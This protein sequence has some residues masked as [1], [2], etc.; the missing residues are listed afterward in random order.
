MQTVNIPVDKLR[1]LIECAKHPHSDPGLAEE[2]E[3][4]LSEALDE[5]EPA[6]KA[7]KKPAAK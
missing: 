6:P 3:A 7:K 4:A 5:S 1:A 2:C